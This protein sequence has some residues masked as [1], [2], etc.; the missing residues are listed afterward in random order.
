MVLF[1][2]FANILTLYE[3]NNASHTLKI[4]FFTINCRNVLLPFWGTQISSNSVLYGR[5]CY[6]CCV[7]FNSSFFSLLNW[8]P[9]LPRSGGHNISFPQFMEFL[10]GPDD[11]VEVRNEHWLSFHRLCSPCDVKYDFL[12]KYETLKEDSEAVLK[13]M[14]VKVWLRRI[15]YHINP[16]WTEFFFSSFFGT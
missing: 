15:F 5:F 9:S 6:I 14:E 10:A 7:V 16:L 12:G 2:C 3:I 1:Y 11:S 13:W 8:L 4:P